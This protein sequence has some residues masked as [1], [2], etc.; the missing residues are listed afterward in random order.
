MQYQKPTLKQVIS[1]D[2]L[3]GSVV[4]AYCSGGNNDGTCTNGTSPP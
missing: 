4:R 3:K 2:K 1:I